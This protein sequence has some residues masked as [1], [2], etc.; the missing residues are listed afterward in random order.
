MK[1]DIPHFEPKDCP[2]NIATWLNKKQTDGLN[3]IS[4]QLYDYHMEVIDVKQDVVN[5]KFAARIIAVVLVL[6]TI[7][8]FVK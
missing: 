2:N 7:F 6:L 8:S 5:L 1:E 4:D 3:G